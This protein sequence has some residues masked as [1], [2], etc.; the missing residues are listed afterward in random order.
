MGQTHGE[1]GYYVLLLFRFL[2]Y[3]PLFWLHVLGAALGWLAWLFSPTYRRHMR[4]NMVLALGTDGERRHRCAAIANAAPSHRRARTRPIFALNPDFPLGPG[5]A[6]RAVA[7][8][9]GPD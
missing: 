6:A 2:S 5:M 4:E 8:Q 7:R 1:Q 9:F 3:L